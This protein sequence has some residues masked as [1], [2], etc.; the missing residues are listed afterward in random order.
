[1]VWLAGVG[2]GQTVAPAVLKNSAAGAVNR[3]YR[4][5]PSG[6]SWCDTGEKA[7]DLRRALLDAVDSAAFFGLDRR[8]YLPDLLQWADSMLR[9]GQVHAQWRDWD[10]WYT[11][12]ALAFA[13]DLYE[14][15]GVRERL[16]YDGVS[17]SYTVRDDQ[18]LAEGL[19]RVGSGAGLRGWMADL[20]PDGPGY[21]VMRDSLAGYLAVARDSVR[22]LRT[23]ASVRVARLGQAMNA[24]RWVDHF[25]F[26]RRIVVSI[27]SAELRYYQGDSLRLRMKVVVGEP[28]KR[29]PRFAAWCDGVVLYPY[30]NV[31]HKIAARELL[32]LFKLTPTVAA[33]MEFQVV[34][35]RGRQVDP[36]KLPWASYTAANFP[37]QVRQAP[38]C[39]NALG[40]IRFN[41]NSPFDV[42]M[43]DTN[44][45]EAFASAYRY[46]SHGCIRLERPID[47]GVALLDDH[48][49][50]TFLKSCFK[51]Q[52]PIPVTLDK[53]V[54]VFVLYSTV[55]VA[56]S[57]KL[58]WY[59]DVYHLDN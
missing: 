58:T 9:A 30:W 16:S 17:G 47:L 54:P 14:G 2:Y 10:R 7:S 3:F 15:A 56:P 19:A 11:E 44:T 37:Y 18:Y 57:G 41:I 6:L 12:A 46:Y 21:R 55:G 25:H 8:D 34:D 45:K 49:D 36:S 1:M 5:V 32:P 28:S 52:R 35:S 48:L 4:V 53:A 13:R 42:Y 24:L 22:A 23:Q 38:G 29:T 51:D 20:V 27:A 31:P 59:K 33:S 26:D 50:T 40:V 43:H 39:F